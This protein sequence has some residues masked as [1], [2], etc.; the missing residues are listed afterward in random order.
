[1][2][3][4]QHL[5]AAGGYAPLPFTTAS[6]PIIFPAPTGRL[7]NGSDV[8][9]TCFKILSAYGRRCAQKALLRFVVISGGVS[10]RT[11]NPTRKHCNPLLITNSFAQDMAY[12]RTVPVVIL[13]HLMTPLMVLT[14]RNSRLLMTVVAIYAATVNWR[15]VYMAKPDRRRAC[16]HPA[17]KTG[18]IAQQMCRLS[19]STCVFCS[20]MMHPVAA[21]VAGAI[22]LLCFNWHREP[23][24]TID[25]QPPSLFDAD[26]LRRCRIS[27]GVTAA[28]LR[29]SGQLP[30]VRQL[31]VNIW[32]IPIGPAVGIPAHLLTQLHARSNLTRGRS[33][34]LPS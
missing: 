31:I 11:A 10:Q 27:I 20:A 1:M 18:T 16:Q 13:A 23:L 24:N 34:S 4:P 28:C 8:S 32:C 15:A 22:S 25:T 9:S 6:R 5:P 30:T 21:G 29:S 33:G 3:C 19:L 26:V 14:V 12:S 2:L 7:G 17:L